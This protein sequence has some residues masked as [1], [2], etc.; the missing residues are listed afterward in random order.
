MA[1]I[2]SYDHMLGSFDPVYCT[3]CIFSKGNDGKESCK[4]S[5]QEI[6]WS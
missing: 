6:K 2:I 4:I 3:L 5:C 1:V